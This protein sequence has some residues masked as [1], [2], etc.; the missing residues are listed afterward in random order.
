MVKKPTKSVE[1]KE[2]LAPLE[3]PVEIHDELMNTLIQVTNTAI[4]TAT[5]L[6][7]GTQNGAAA[8][9]RLLPA[10]LAESALGRAVMWRIELHGLV[11][12]MAPLGLDIIG[13]VILGRGGTS[14]DAPDLDL[15]PYGAFESGVSR[16]HAMLRPSRTSLYLIDLNSTN[17]TWHNALRL[18]SGIT[19]AL[20]DNDT[21]T[22]GR[23]TFTIRILGNASMSSAAPPANDAPP[24][25]PDVSK[26]SKL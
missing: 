25:P 11:R 15:D 10:R 19:R 7:F 23:L 12:D 6:P 22:L 24:S 5:E 18:N 17:G 3:V 26:P 1:Q 20:N 21:V 2:K 4:L 14:G 9:Y 13:D 16:Q 8:T